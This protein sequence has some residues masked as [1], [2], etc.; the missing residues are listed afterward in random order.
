MYDSKISFEIFISYFYTEMESLSHENY[1]TDNYHED[2]QECYGCN[3][4][5]ENYEEKRQI[6]E[7]DAKICEL[8]R[9]DS[10][11]EFIIYVN[12]NN[13]SLSS[14]VPLSIFETSPLI[15]DNTSLIQYAAFFGSIQIFKYL[16]MN[17]VPVKSFDLFF[18][19]HGRN[20][21]I[22]HILEENTDSGG[23]EDFYKDLYEY[24]IEC[25]HNEMMSYYRDNF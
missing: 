18:G 16:M 14:N 4:D 5:T 3:F 13:I 20:P 7:N 10:L 9:K 22:I 11:D 25:Y 8:I 24:S 19:I 1:D 21:E 15:R 23:R 17:G 6:G 2:F 12:K